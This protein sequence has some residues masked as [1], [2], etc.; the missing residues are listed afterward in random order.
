M[1]ARN[2]SIVLLTV[3]IF[4]DVMAQ[5]FSEELALLLPDLLFPSYVQ[6]EAYAVG[7]E[8]RN[9]SVFFILDAISSFLQGNEAADVG[10]LSKGAEEM[11]VSHV[12][13]DGELLFPPISVDSEAIAV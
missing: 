11:E 12:V 7:I 10:I 13:S 2:F 6:H 8:T 4:S 3:Q 1:E 5:I 9:K